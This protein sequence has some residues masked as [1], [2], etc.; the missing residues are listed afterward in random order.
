MT[1]RAVICDVPL[2]QRS[3]APYQVHMEGCGTNPR[4][5]YFEDH[6]AAA[7]YAA[8]KAAGGTVDDRSNAA[9]GGGGA[10]HRFP[11]FAKE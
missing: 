8:L 5:I 11:P 9:K 2:G 1:R 3:I 10:K 7:R 6:P 4:P